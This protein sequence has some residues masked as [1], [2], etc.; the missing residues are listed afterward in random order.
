V[1]KPLAALVALAGFLHAGSATAQW[2]SLSPN[3]PTKPPPPLGA[4]TSAA[5]TPTE[6]MVPGKVDSRI[7]VDVGIGP[8][9]AP[10][11]VT[12]T[13]R[14]RLHGTGDYSFVVPAP[15]TRVIPGPGSESEPGLRDVGIVWAGFSDRGRV[16]SATASLRPSE[17][18]AGLPL[19]VRVERRGGSTVVRL[20]NLA[21]RRV[22]LVTGRAKLAKLISVLENV[23]ALYGRS[24]VR[25]V[26]L[27][28]RGEAGKYL[29]LELAAR[30]RVTG[31][32][33]QGSSRTTVDEEL[34]GGRPL[35]R[36]FVVPGAG[37]PTLRLRVELVAPLEILPAAG[38]LA[39][40]SQPLVT[41][42]KALGAIA[43]SAAYGRYLDA[44]APA[45]PSE[46]S[47]VYR[48]APRAA[49]IGRRAPGGGG[50]DA[51]LIVLASLLAAAAVG[52]LA[53]LWARS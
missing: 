42:Q 53:V 45:A 44:P 47:Y 1:S 18:A 34:G 39:A 16:L 14:L 46:T 15:A 11:R 40:A 25:A 38:E 35:E 23:R 30:L 9:G 12:A 28:V 22:V 8:D 31:T 32:A 26:P 27:Y 49:A 24:R 37:A 13:Q 10:V 29:E 36:T 33:S 50:G 4:G 2:L 43:I 48:S 52:G 19:Q 51:L 5:Q 21:H 17:A 7:L 6:L 41:L 20:A 3:V